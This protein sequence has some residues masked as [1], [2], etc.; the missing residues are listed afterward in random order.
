MELEPIALK[1]EQAGLG[2]RAKSIFVHAMPVECKKGI[3]L[4]SPLQGTAIDHEL[5]GYYKAEFSVICRSHSHSEAV[6]MANQATQALKG[7]NVT[8]GPIEAKH[9]LPNHL[10]VVFPVSEGNFVE[11]LV[12]FDICFCQ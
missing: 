9:L 2:I 4:R 5:P 3:L 8:I 1:L 11:A 6:A 10:P 12:K 7:Y